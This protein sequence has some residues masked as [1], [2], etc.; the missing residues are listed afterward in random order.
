MKDTNSR[1]HFKDA[2]SATE[3]KE[4]DDEDDDNDSAGE[5]T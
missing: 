4:P 1:C 3:T 5:V 2:L